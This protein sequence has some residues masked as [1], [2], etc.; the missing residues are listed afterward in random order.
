MMNE[1]GHLSGPMCTN[2]TS[3]RI[4]VHIRRVPMINEYTRD[5]LIDDIH[6]GDNDIFVWCP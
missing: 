6:H 5:E 1:P 3:D 4:A 2:I